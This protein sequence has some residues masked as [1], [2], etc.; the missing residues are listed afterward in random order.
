MPETKRFAPLPEDVS[1]AP[2]RAESAVLEAWRRDRVFEA[3]QASRANAEPFVFWEGPPTA[4]GRPGIHHVLARTIK[5]VVCRW[6]TMLGKRVLRKA[7]W[8][9]HG[10]PVELEVEKRLGINGKPEIERYGIA[11]FNEE[12]RKSVWTYRKEWEELSER[13]G[14]WLDYEHPYVTYEPEYVESVWNLLKRFHDAGLV[15]RGKKVLPYCGR[16]GTGLSS[17][18][19]GQPG[20]YRDVNDPSVILR[21]RLEDPAGTEPE[22][23]LAWTTTPWTLPSNFALAVHPERSYVR[24]RVPL[25]AG[26]EIVWVV[27]PRAEAVLPKGFEVLERKR[28][29]DLVGKRYLPL[30]TASGQPVVAGW[31]AREPSTLHSVHAAEFVTVEDGTGIVHQAPYGADDWELARREQLPIGLAVGADGRFE[32]DVGPVRAGTWFKDADDALMDDLKSRGLLFEK[33]RSTHSYPH[34]WRCSQPLYYFPA[35]AWYIRTSSYKDRMVE[36]NRRIRWVPPEVG[37]KRFGEWLENNIDW[38]ISRD[39]YWGTPLP[40]WVC[41]GCDAEVAV[42]SLAELTQRAGR[43]PEGFDLHK[44]SIDD[45]VFACGTCAGTMRRTR[46]VLDCWFDSGAMPYA[47]F[48]WP[49]GQGRAAVR[50]QFPADFIA[51][52]V[53]QTRGWFYTLHAIGAF[54]T[55]SSDAGLP[56]GPAYRTCVVNGLVLDKDGVKMSKRLGNVVDPWKVLE[57]HGA[58]ALRWYLLGSGQPWLNK[59]FDPAGVLEVRRRFLGTLTN[60]YKF[61]AEYARIDAFDPADPRIPPPESRPEIDRWL[62]SRAQSLILEVRARMGDFDLSGACRSLETFVVDDLSNWYIRRNRRRFWKSQ[63]GPDKLAAFSSLHDALE[64]STRLAAPILPF[65]AESLWQRLAGAASLA[66]GAGSVHSQSVPVAD[67]DRI[68]GILEGSMRT[69]TRI[70]ELGRKLRERAGVKNR[71]PLRAIHVRS[72]EPAALRLLETDFARDL[73]LGELN[74]KEWGSLAADDGALCQLKPK[75]NWPRLGKRLGAKMKAAAAAI[76]ALPAEEIDRL[77]SGIPVLVRIDGEDIEISPEDVQVMVES[78]A[79]FPIE[80]DGRF[81]VFLDMELDEALL[82]EG[83]A[84]E[85]INRVNGLRKDS[86]LAVEDRIDLHLDGGD[87]ALLNRAF[88]EYRTLIQSETLAVHLSVD[89]TPSAGGSEAGRAA[90]PIDEGRTLH[91]KLARAQSESGG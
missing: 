9:T 22:S 44:P 8:D 36:L 27:E 33:A 87:D 23:L 50:D 34:C 78:R 91:V 16:C 24:A 68:D 74:V 51:E 21:F 42:G 25:G 72:S 48:H 43:L 30:F 62:L 90:F 15:Y 61:F 84:R 49:F 80:T 10:L 26:H 56:D 29:A 71:Q 60:S 31:Q 40:F 57:E 18:E 58:D 3:V 32:A 86:G 1:T 77:R 64:I 17:H 4:N 14:Y 75:P 6:Q 70:V 54:L 11:A 20:V 38:N 66:A 83:L 88:A 76:Q 85:V 12:C 37:Q 65:L 79:D 73:V 89:A 45:I 55:S 47:Q 52:G 13:I 69:V 19:L 5:D 63:T 2:N 35:P 7:G 67:A 53:D 41:D 46:S 39:R 28:G 82:V 81:V 59:R